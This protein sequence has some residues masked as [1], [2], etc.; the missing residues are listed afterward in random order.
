MVVCSS[1]RVQK[2]PSTTDSAMVYWVRM[3]LESLSSSSPAQSA[4]LKFHQIDI[5]LL[6][7]ETEPSDVNAVDFIV[8][9]AREKVAKLEKRI[10][11]LSIAD[12][13]DDA[14]LEASWL[15]TGFHPTKDRSGGWRMRMHS[16]LS[17]ICSSLLSRRTIWIS[18]LSFGLKN[19][20]QHT[21]TFSL[22]PRIRKVSSSRFI[23]S[24][25][26]YANLVKQAKSKQ[27]ITDK[28]EAAGLVEK[29]ET[30]RPLRF[31]F[32]GIRKLPPIIAFD[33]VAFSYSGNPEDYLYK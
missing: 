13:V 32:E 33:E 21:T 24:A 12:D 19:I 15:Q 27:N 17:H 18:A 22:S 29:V 23:A 30:P 11:D 9:S 4:T 8:A 16:L 3:S 14:A 1:S 20:Y 10:E 25:G 28:M 31:H 7:G 2:P 26:T 5:Y 6:R